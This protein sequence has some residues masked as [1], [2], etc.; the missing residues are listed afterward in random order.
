MHLSEHI[1]NPLRELTN[2]AEEVNNGN[3]EIKLNYDGNDE[4]G[5]LTRTFNKLISNLKI[6]IGDLNNLAYA[7]ALTSLR[8]KGACDTYTEKLQNQ[9]NESN[10]E[11]EFAIGI[12]D[13]NNLKL[14]NDLYGHDKGDI[15]L[16]NSSALIC[17]IFQHSPVFRTGG[18]EFTI[19]LQNED[20]QN[21]EKLIRILSEKSI[22]ISKNTEKPW[23][24][25]SVAIGIAEYNPKIDSSVGDVMRRA[26]K[27][28][29]EHKRKLKTRKKPYR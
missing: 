6:H 9:I 15:Y 27:L 10:G 20:F 14:I 24:K 26:D 12:S 29:Y 8:N 19:I 7:D 1:T 13:C 22:E 25:I 5:I 21:R 3:Y 11:I 28:M 23:E 2:M 16:K 18:D 17:K 4:V